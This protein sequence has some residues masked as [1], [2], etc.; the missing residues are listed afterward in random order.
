MEFKR[1]NYRKQNQLNNGEMV[2]G[3]ISGGMVFTD[4]M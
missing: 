4:F 1:T 2:D 3:E